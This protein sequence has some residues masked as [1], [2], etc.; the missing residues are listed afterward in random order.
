MY[1][2]VIKSTKYLDIKNKRNRDS[3]KGNTVSGYI[4]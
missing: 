4:R 2:G 1:L 3:E